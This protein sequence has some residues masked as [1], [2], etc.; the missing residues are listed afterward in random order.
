MASCC[1]MSLSTSMHASTSSSGANILRPTSLHC[2]LSR[3]ALGRPPPRLYCSLPPTSHLLQTFGPRPH[4]SKT[5]QRLRRSLKA[6]KTKTTSSM[7][8]TLVGMRPWTPRNSPSTAMWSSSGRQRSRLRPLLPVPRPLSHLPTNL[9]SQP[10]PRYHAL[11]PLQ[12]VLDS[13]LSTNPV[14]RH[15]LL[16]VDQCPPPPAPNSF[17]QNAPLLFSATTTML[18]HLGLPIRSSLQVTPTRN[19]ITPWQKHRHRLTFAGSTPTTIAIHAAL[20][21]HVDH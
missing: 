11:F 16:T 1:R 13:R 20:L 19:R 7:D 4:R 3:S 18:L 6:P 17:A 21:A 5:N 14:L 8:W 9:R 12:A 10:C 2:P 15:S